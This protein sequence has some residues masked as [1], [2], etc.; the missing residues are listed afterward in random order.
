MALDLRETALRQSHPS[1]LST[2]RIESTP[3]YQAEFDRLLA[4]AAKAE[5]AFKKAREEYDRAHVA[6]VRHI[7]SRHYR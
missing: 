7:E 5:K 3:E 4:I 6:L 1:D 2:P